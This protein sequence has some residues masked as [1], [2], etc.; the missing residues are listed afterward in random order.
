M[1]QPLHC[2]EQLDLS[3]S[4]DSNSKVL[5]NGPKSNEYK[6][7]QKLVSY[8]TIKDLPL[9]CAPGPNQLIETESFRS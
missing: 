3:C 2:S 8:L 9:N 7:D 1:E 4:G 5:E 6:S